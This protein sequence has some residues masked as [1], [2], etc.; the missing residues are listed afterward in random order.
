MAL[1]TFTMRQLLEAGVHFGHQSRRWN[2]RMEPYIHGKRG[3]VHIINI[4][5]TVKGLLLAKKLVQNTVAG[6]GTVPPQTLEAARGN[7]MSAWQIYY[8]RRVFE[9]KRRI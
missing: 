7:G 3:N 2:P 1:P 5:E 8:L 9:A 6:L 4:K